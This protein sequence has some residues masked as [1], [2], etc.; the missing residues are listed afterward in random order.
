M[1]KKII[2][3]MIGMSC[4]SHVSTGAEKPGLLVLT[5]IGGDPDDRQSMVRLLLYANEYN[6]EGFIA[7]ASGTPGELDRAVVRPDL[8]RE[9]VTAYGTVRDNLLLHQSGYPAHTELLQKI[10]PG[11]PH[12]GKEHI[13]NNHDTEGSNW[14]IR[15]VDQADTRPVNICVWGGQT[16]LVQALWRVRHDRPVKQYEKFIDKIRIYDIADQDNLFD[17]FFPKHPGLFYILNKAPR[18]EDKR[19][20]AF[21]GMYLGGNESLTSRDWIDTHVR[22]RHGALGALYPPKTWTAPNPHGVLKEGDTPSWFYFLANGLNDAENPEFGGWGGR[23]VPAPGGHYRDAQDTLDSLKNARVTVWRWRPDFQNDFQA[24]MDWCVLPRDRANHNPLVRLRGEL[25][26]NVKIGEPL[27]LDASLSS[28]PDGDDLS[29]LW[30]VYPEAGTF[31]GDI[32]IDNKDTA[33]M[34]FMATR[35]DKAGQVHVICK[36]VDNGTPNL[37]AYQRLIFNVE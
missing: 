23:F 20:A 26:R 34:N 21:R 2:V 35:V 1:L 10:K 30:F 9:I 33:R 7:T 13:G 14:I 29:F 8:I 31:T 36:V 12:R 15:V 16:D 37:C 22:T 18:G 28:D 6:I 19:K 32:K 27:T 4:F 25:N 24:R 3:L 5:D 11:N 17:W